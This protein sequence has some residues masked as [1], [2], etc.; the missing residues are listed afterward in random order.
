MRSLRKVLVAPVLVAMSGALLHAQTPPPAPA[1]DASTA[2][3]PAS[4]QATLSVEE[5]QAQVARYDTQ[6]REAARHVEQLRVVAR[7]QKDVIKLNCV[8]DKAVQIKAT[9]NIVDAAMA[10]LEVAIMG[11]DDEARYHEFT[12]ITISSEKARQLRDEADGC[13][14]EE[15]SYVGDTI[16]EVNQP[17]IPD[18]PTLDD[19]FEGDIEPPAYASPFE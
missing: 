10:S 15:L 12:K 1:P 7:K 18:D 3:A 14:G 4:Q 13:V 11:R 2:T 17:D 5:M 16:V 8:N 6:N 9:L 19:P